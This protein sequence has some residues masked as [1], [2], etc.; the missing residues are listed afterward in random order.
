M[1]S[2]AVVSALLAAKGDQYVFIA[3]AGTQKATIS[4]RVGKR[5]DENTDA[6]QQD[7]RER[8]I[9]APEISSDAWPAYEG[10]VEQAFGSSCFVTARL[11]R[12]MRESLRRTPRGVTAPAT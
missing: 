10:A 1:I 2:R 8:I 12:P 7:L 9:N 6:F 3:M 4:Y 5:N 11:S